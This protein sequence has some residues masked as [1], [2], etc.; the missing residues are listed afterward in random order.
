MKD[1]LDF[2]KKIQETLAKYSKTTE[3]MFT[4]QQ[5]MM[6]KQYDTLLDVVK[7]VNSIDLGLSTKPTV[8]KEAAKPAPKKATTKPV[9]KA[10][11]TPV[12]KAEVKVAPK[13]V[14][15]ATP[16]K[17]AEVKVAPKPAA[18]KATPAPIKKETVKAAPKKV[19]NRKAK[20]SGSKDRLEALKQAT[21]DAVKANRL[22]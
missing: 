22:N 6:Q 17:K 1:A 8:K 9:V 13:P 18:K 15:K 12:K 14:V 16:V 4:Y 21:Q 10:A 19:N 2:N 11:A 3:S 5:K 20:K 7:T